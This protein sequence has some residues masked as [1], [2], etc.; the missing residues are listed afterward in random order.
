MTTSAVTNNKIVG[1]LDYYK[2]N[3]TPKDT[4]K[5]TPSSDKR[6]KSSMAPSSQTAGCIG[7]GLTVTFE[8][9]LCCHT[10][11]LMFE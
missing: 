4:F 6:K 10:D 1:I 11:P 5:D 3:I 7:V 2:R 8:L 9:T